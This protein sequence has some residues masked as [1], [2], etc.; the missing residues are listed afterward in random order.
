VAA[1]AD[2][3]KANKELIKFLARELGVGRYNIEIVSGKT[4]RM[5]LVEIACS[6]GL[7]KKLSAFTHH[8]E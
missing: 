4:S 2:D 3:G 8:E 7:E 5:K 6:D 1:V